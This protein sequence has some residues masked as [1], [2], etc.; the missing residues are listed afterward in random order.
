MTTQSGAEEQEVTDA[1]LVASR[2][3]V[4]I[5]A[6]SLA[7]LDAITLPQFRALVVLA[8]HDDSTVGSLADELDIHPSTATRLCDRLADKNL[9]RR[10]PGRAGDRRE[11]ALTLTARGRGLVDRVSL[12]RHRELRRV[13]AAMSENERRH[14]LIGLRAFA[15]AAGDPRAADAFG[16]SHPEHRR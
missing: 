12:K 13:V 3:L 2:A 8:H 10:T 6:R 16:W 14:A 15:A 9:I 11:T 4:A 5:A 7:D 1:F